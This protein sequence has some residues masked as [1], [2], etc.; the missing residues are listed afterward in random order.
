MQTHPGRAGVTRCTVDALVETVTCEL[1]NRSIGLAGADS[2][3]RWPP[4]SRPLFREGGGGW[5]ASPR[6][7][8]RVR[9]LAITIGR[10]RSAS[11]KAREEVGCFPV[12]LRYRRP[13]R[14]AVAGA[15]ACRGPADVVIRVESIP[16]AHAGGRHGRR[17]LGSG[18]RGL[19]C[20]DGVGP[21]WCARGADGRGP[22]LWCG[23]SS[24][25]PLDPGAGLALLLH[26]RGLYVVHASAVEIA[27]SAVAF[28][29]PGVG[30][31]PPWR[32][33]CTGGHALVADDLTAINGVGDSPMVYPGFPRLA[34]AG[35][36]CSLGSRPR[37]APA[38]SPFREARTRR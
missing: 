21:S 2:S 34:V 19:P 32:R 20:S 9:L 29:Q 5:F 1:I 10:G 15:R 33:P 25:A 8:G 28:R 7:G 30:A 27:G 37:I 35:S 4:P 11:R 22:G 31:S 38:A 16:V 26:Q 6:G 24:P 18:G 12:H 3:R 36:P 14:L 23:G 17:V 13:V